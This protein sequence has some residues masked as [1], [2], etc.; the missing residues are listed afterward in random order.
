MRK[1]VVTKVVNNGCTNIISLLI[2]CVTVTIK[3]LVR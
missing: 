1:K 2:N 3:V